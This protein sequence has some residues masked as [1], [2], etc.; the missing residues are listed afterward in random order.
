MIDGVQIRP[1]KVNHDIPDTEHD[2]GKG[3]LMEVV[4]A[5]E[6]LLSSFAQSV[7][8][9][10]YGRG[11]IKAFHWHEKQDD[12]WFI[13]SGTAR[14]VLYDRRPGSL[15]FGETQT[16]NAGADDY[17]VILI[18][19]G[20]AHGYQVLSDDPVML[21]YHVTREYDREHPDEERIPYN[22]PTIN[23]NWKL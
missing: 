23:V 18:P 14:I 20:V 5:R 11:T 19:A 6:G 1:C 15:T 2:E 8:T 9:I 12:L 3:I 22:D 21:F 13:A 17:K 10:S 16:M 4:R 7:F